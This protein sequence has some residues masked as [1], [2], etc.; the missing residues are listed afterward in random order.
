MSNVIN[1]PRQSINLILRNNL[2]RNYCGRLFREGV[3]GGNYTGFN[4]GS[5]ARKRIDKLAAFVA[6]NEIYSIVTGPA[7]LLSKE[8]ENEVI[9]A[10]NTMIDEANKTIRGEFNSNHVRKM[11][12]KAKDA[13]IERAE[14]DLKEE[15]IAPFLLAYQMEM[16]KEVLLD[17]IEN[18]GS[19]LLTIK[20]K[21]V[22]Q[23]AELSTSIGLIHNIISDCI[24]S[25]SSYINDHVSKFKS[26][27]DYIPFIVALCSKIGFLLTNW[28]M[29]FVVEYTERMD[30]FFGNIHWSLFQ[31]L[32]MF[33]SFLKFIENFCDTSN[34]EMYI[35]RFKNDVSSVKWDEIWKQ[36]QKFLEFYKFQFNAFYT[37][38]L[39]KYPRFGIVNSMLI[40]VDDTVQSQITYESIF[41]IRLLF[42]YFKP[43][44]KAIFIPPQTLDV[45]KMMYIKIPVYISLPQFDSAY[46]TKGIEW[47]FI[48]FVSSPSSDFADKNVQAM[49]V[50]PDENN[51]SQFRKKGPKGKAKKL[52]LS[53]DSGSIFLA[54]LED[55]VD[56]PNIVPESV[57]DFRFI[58]FKPKKLPELQTDEV[59]VQPDASNPPIILPQSP[60]ISFPPPPPLILPSEEEYKKKKEQEEERRKKKEE[61]NKKKKENEKK[62]NN[63]GGNTQLFGPG[64]MP[65]LPKPG[66]GAKFKLA[67][68][69]VTINKQY[70]S[71][72]INSNGD[73]MAINYELNFDNITDTL[74]Q[75]YISYIVK[76]LVE[77]WELDSESVKTRSTLASKKDQLSPEELSKQLKKG[78]TTQRTLR[79]VSQ[80]EI[81]KH[82]EEVKKNTQPDILVALGKAME[83]RRQS[84]GEYDEEEEDKDEGWTDKM[85]STIEISQNTNESQISNNSNITQN[86]N[87]KDHTIYNNISYD[88]SD[89]LRINKRTAEYITF[90]SD[91]KFPEIKE[92]VKF[93]ASFFT[94]SQYVSLLYACQFFVDSRDVK[95]SKI[96]KEK[97][98]YETSPLQKSDL[99]KIKKELRKK[100]AIIMAVDHMQLEHIIRDILSS[101][102]FSLFKIEMNKDDY[103]L[104]ILNLIK[105][106]DGSNALGIPT[107]DT[108]M[109]SQSLFFL[110]VEM[111]KFYSQA[112]IT[113][114]KFKNKVFMR[115][116][117]ST[118]Y[119]L[120]QLLYLSRMYQTYIPELKIVMT[121]HWADLYDASGNVSSTDHWL[122]F[123]FKSYV[124]NNIE[125]ANGFMYLI[126][127]YYIICRK[128]MKTYESLIS[129][130]VDEKITRKEHHN[131]KL[132]K[133][134]RKAEKINFYKETD[135]KLIQFLERIQQT[136]VSSPL[137]SK[138]P[139]EKYVDIHKSGARH[140][141]YWV[142]FYKFRGIQ[143][144][145]MILFYID[146]IV[147]HFKRYG[148]PNEK[149]FIQKDEKTGKDKGL[150]TKVFINEKNN[151]GNLNDNVR[152]F[153]DSCHPIKLMASIIL[154]K[155]KEV[156]NNVDMTSIDT[157]P[158]KTKQN[159]LHEII[160]YVQFESEKKD[161]N[162]IEK[163]SE[164]IK[165]AIANMLYFFEQ[166]N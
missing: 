102:T 55:Y 5:D 51:K 80:E 2:V 45:M 145:E 81:T 138:N 21:E 15:K 82:K 96:I 26:D 54:E 97:K 22:S 27:E 83:T 79:K 67:P 156:N 154:K 151:N 91:E 92:D 87:T 90:I 155:I 118:L 162:N 44:F 74:I 119:S 125:N 100:K 110:V 19:F 25:V 128:L 139:I 56:S 50:E 12:R 40:I 24:I 20:R 88:L 47:D 108:Y 65:Q 132:W 129:F 36:L 86:D 6:L 1:F 84:L 38:S 105:K 16:T 32:Y 142:M 9:Y 43:T 130:N 104:S 10:L 78:I 72:N 127:I 136:I 158:C 131:D 63:N 52:D 41:L 33:L 124:N 147:E 133:D 30:G 71:T 153:Y 29:K 144:S 120:T 150:L 11:S 57:S 161:G 31:E 68:A 149:I 103:Y 141:P 116:I 17:T 101:T 3:L 117:E 59:F 159:V 70:T 135:A 95:K 49:I 109:K 121:N 114:E 122:H 28:Q 23:L 13:I 115:T 46:V 34:S 143:F 66:Q 75:K 140:D 62:A 76:K 160:N 85:L 58:D 112:I 77:A 37:N 94:A 64:Q 35:A 165:A 164:G 107:F 61:E 148:V 152:E 99:T 98:K 14:S 8:S 73:I 93:D 123:F 106:G 48:N 134:A 4:Y 60:I 111:F 89:S 126:M 163:N 42:K 39:K 157:K 137:N 166:I 146:D 113:F 53:I 7:C 18:I 69:V